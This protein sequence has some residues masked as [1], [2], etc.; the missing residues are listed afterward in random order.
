MGRGR[1]ELKRIEN[2]MNRQVTFSKRRNGLL[3]KAYELSL[4][5]DAEVALIIFSSPGKLY[6]FCSTSS[7]TEMIE[8]YDKCSYTT[9]DNCRPI[10][11]TQTQAMLRQLG[12]L[13]KREQMLIEAN[14]SLRRK[15]EELSPQVPQGLGW[16]NN[17]GQSSLYNRLSTAQWVGFFQP[18][19]TN[20]SSQRGFPLEEEEAAETNPPSSS[21]H[22]KE[23]IVFDR[24]EKDDSGGKEINMPITLSKNTVSTDKESENSSRPCFSDEDYIVFCFKEDGAFIVMEDGNKSD[25]SNPSSWPVNPMVKLQSAEDAESDKGRSNEA[26]TSAAKHQGD[27][28]RSNI[29][30]EVEDRP[31]HR[32][33]VSVESSGSNQSDGSTGSFAFPVYVRMGVDGKSS[34]N[35]KITRHS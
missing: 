27:G 18:L 14:K 2:K 8:K 33:T 3:K 12:D 20:S 35:A 30:W 29:W 4:L 1:V 31:S 15:L 13:R 25:E 5:C 28:E 22:P 19:G 26:E 10:I 32:G 23:T 24:K 21:N 17:G 9:L 7:M 34:A 11:E 16:E 6:E